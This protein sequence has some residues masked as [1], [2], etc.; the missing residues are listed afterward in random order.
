MRRMEEWAGENEDPVVSQALKNFKASMDAWSEAAMSQP[1]T[2]KT[3]RHTW[4]LATAWA[5]GCVVAAGSL[6]G[7]LYER[8]HRQE[9]ARIAA[10]Q[11]AEQQKAMTAEPPATGA[12]TEDQDLLATVDS[13]ISREVPAAMDPLAQL[14]DDNGTR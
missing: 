14:M 2:V 7:G 4:R 12:L 9:L 10:A 11:K 8:H 13:D 1:R 5:L 6:S 3:V